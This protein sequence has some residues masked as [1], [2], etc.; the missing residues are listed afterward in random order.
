MKKLGWAFVVVALLTTGCASVKSPQQPGSDSTSAQVPEHPNQSEPNQSEPNQNELNQGETNQT[1]PLQT[2]P[3]QPTPDSLTPDQIEP[4][5]FNQTP[6]PVSALT[7]ELIKQG[8]VND[9]RLNEI[10]GLAGSNYQPNLLWALNDSGHPPKLYRLNTSAVVID[11]WDVKANNRDWEALASTV[12]QGRSYLL[13]AET[14]DNLQVHDEARIHIVLEPGRDALSSDVLTPI[15]TLR[16]RYEGGPRNVEAMSV[17]GGEILLLTKERLVN[18][19][20][21]PSQ[22]F[23]LPLSLQNSNDTQ[24]AQHRGSLTAPSRGIDIGLLSYMLNFDPLQPTD[25]SISFDGQHAYVLNYVHVLHYSKML[26]E[27][28]Q[29]AFSRKPNVLH[30]HGLRQAEALTVNA[31]GEVWVTSE[32]NNAPLLG[33]IPFDPPLNFN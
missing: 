5:I 1:T 13:I 21:V 23:S 3:N 9:A 14:G 6:L 26:G 11:V 2:S 19:N 33:F 30:R 32:K 12:I 15:N 16:F 4:L 7:R 31:L 25:L 10:S 20:S 28:W 18:G 29:E 24:L 8:T 22:I 27:S 17:S